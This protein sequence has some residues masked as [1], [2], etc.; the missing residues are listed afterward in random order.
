MLCEMAGKREDAARYTKQARAM[1]EQWQK[2]AFDGDHYK[3][4]F[5]KPGSWSQKYNLVWDKL[6]GLNLFP[7]EIARTEIA[8]YLKRQQ[9]YGLPLDSRGTVCKND[10]SIWAATMAE[11]R[12]DFEAIVEPLYTFAVETPSRVPLT[13][14]YWCDK[15]VIRNFQARSVVG[16][17]FIKLLADEAL[18]MKWARRRRA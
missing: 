3:L 4:A 7:A 12:A 2:M 16:G 14:C 13:D 6:V 1:A 8:S 17:F 9:P 15:G 11:S 10:W 5:D 18:W